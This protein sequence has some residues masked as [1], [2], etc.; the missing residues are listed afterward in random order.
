MLSIFSPGL[1]EEIVQEAKSAI[2]LRCLEL[3]LDFRSQFRKNPL[4]SVS[5]EETAPL[6]PQLSLVREMTQTDDVM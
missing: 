4:S 2:T 6:S 5:G 1:K 3:E